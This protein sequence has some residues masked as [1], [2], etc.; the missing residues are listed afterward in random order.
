MDLEQV[1]IALE[2]EKV[3]LLNEIKKIAV[4]DNDG[5]FDA[6]ETMSDAS[7]VPDGADLASEQTEF[8]KNQA[9]LS[10]LEERLDNVDK[11]L[12]R[13]QTGTFGVCISCGEEIPEARLG[14]NHAAAKCIACEEKSEKQ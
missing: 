3:E 8:A 10:E 1:K 4:K 6:K 7:D 14:A 13:I 9:I 2:A 5:E 11:A 12:V